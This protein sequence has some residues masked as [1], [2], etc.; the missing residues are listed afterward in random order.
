[1][2]LIEN[3]VW[4][5]R[6][7]FSYILCAAISSHTESQNHFLTFPF[8]N[9]DV[10][11]LQGWCYSS[12]AKYESP[13]CPGVCISPKRCHRGIDY[14]DG[15]LFGGPWSSFEVV[16]AAPGRAACS[17][18][19]RLG[20]FVY[21][22][23]NE[24][25][26]QGLQYF[27]LY[28]HLSSVD[29]AIPI[30]SL[31]HLKSDISMGDI[32]TWR[33]VGRGAFLGMSGDIGSPGIIHLHFEIHRGGY[34]L[35]KTD[36]YDIY[37]TRDQYPSSCGPN[38]LWTECPPQQVSLA[39]RVA[40]AS[41]RDGNYEVYVMDA[42][43]SNQ[44][45]L[46]SDP[47]VD[48]GPRWS[49][50]GSKIAFQSN[51][52]GNY[53]LFV[54]DSDGSNLQQITSHPANDFDLSWSP[55]GAWIAFRTDRDGNEEIY[56]VSLAD[57]RIQINLTNNSSRDGEPRW[58]PT[59]GKIL[60]SSWRGGTAEIYVMDDDGSNVQP[61]TTPVTWSSSPTW[62]PDE[63]KI[64]YTS[65]GIVFV[66]DANG[67]NPQPII[68]SGGDDYVNAWSA[69]GDSWALSSNRDGD[70]E[71]FLY[72]TGTTITT[73]LTHNTVDDQSPDFSPILRAAAPKTI[74]M[75]ERPVVYHLQQN[76]PNPFN[77]STSIRYTLPEAR[78]VRLTIYNLLGQ[79]LVRLVD[80]YEERGEHAV[81]FTASDL[82]SGVYFYR[83]E[84][85]EHSEMLKLILMK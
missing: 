79:E 6:I 50:D 5:K 12:D 2:R 45:N 44:H 65:F 3:R 55:D 43:G 34:T 11:I 26:A 42:D 68:N 38:H 82:R 19:E 15:P 74:A 53:D 18:S 41:N 47:A 70:F 64:A 32:S 21:V 56:K 24:V 1:M 27:T 37:G 20:N 60:F 57:T 61:F 76:Y 23:H 28:A 81:E 51:R 69:N 62:S 58:S 46:T 48:G 59:G 22:A 4:P 73:Q 9:P 13:N 7:L 16:G 14:A 10:R 75:I 52:N 17:Y 78:H 40:F 84:A 83:L 31:D 33:E 29:P 63:T 54:M 66:A 8:K 71:I 30:K 49:P 72:D 77:P 85:G 39:P 67:T 80:R 35:N 25:D 36:P